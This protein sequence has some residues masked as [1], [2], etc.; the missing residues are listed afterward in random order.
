MNEISVKS[1]AYQVLDALLLLKKVY[2]HASN[3]AKL[4]QQSEPIAAPPPTAPVSERLRRAS[5]SFDSRLTVSL[6]EWLEF[7]IG[8]AVFYAGEV[9][10]SKASRVHSN[11]SGHMV[12]TRSVTRHVPKS[13]HGMTCSISNTKH[14]RC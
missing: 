11:L 4:D 5:R 2:R 7:L 9:R 12:F 1:S 14:I 8:M 3:K 10:P 6:S 13:I